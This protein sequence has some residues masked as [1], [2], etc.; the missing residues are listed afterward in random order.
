MGALRFLRASVQGRVL[1]FA[2]LVAA[3]ASL[4]AAVLHFF[5]GT[6]T[7]MPYLAHLIAVAASGVAAG[8]AAIALSVVGA[9]RG[10]G[11][12][13]LLGTAFSVMA[14][15]LVVHSLVTPEVLVGANRL[16]AFAGAANLPVG[17]A[18]LA[19]SALPALR[20]P[21]RVRRLLALQV[22]LLAAIGMLAPLAV[23]FP[24]LVPALPEPGTVPA[25]AALGVG[26]VFY[27]VLARRAAQ[28]FLLT[29]RRAD[30]AVVV[31]IVWLAAALIALLTLGYF[32][33]GWWLAHG[34][35][36]AGIVLVGVP[37]VLD[38]HRTAQSRPLL[39][40]LRG[41][42]LVQ[43]EHAFLGPRVHALM[44]RLAEKDAYTEWHTRRVALL[45]VQVGEEL[46]LGP[47]RLRHLAVGGLLHDIGK[48]SVPDAVLQKP[49]PLDDDEYVEIRR[50]PESGERLLTEL[51]GF[52][53]AVHDLVLS[54]HERLDGAGYPQ[55][56]PASALDLETR[57]L[58]V[59]D[60]YDA[61]ISKRV[62]REAWTRD[63]A[64]AL[65]REESGTAFD[66]R[67]VA[68]LERVLEAEGDDGAPHLARAA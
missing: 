7:S 21:G 20:R 41:A 52:A 16:F 63:R 58:S 15:M 43:A 9:R 59:C 61:L 35:E 67:C 29:R 46:G 17:G 27:G 19:L 13:V 2:A 32:D 55:G 22:V 8:G 36:V 45:A 56:V 3:S 47:A 26:V 65:L 48:L 34:F 60:V 44:L 5:A 14:A 11:R 68:A 18:V 57:I 25:F 51:G 42:E 30:L 6:Q 37:A 12:A 40:D 24:S 31:G 66:A 38:L 39:G 64:L 54:H 33:L 10:D 1:P 28:T 53:P 62:Y 23:A 49:G 4:P 50:H